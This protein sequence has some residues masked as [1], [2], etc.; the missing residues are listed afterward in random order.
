MSPPSFDSAASSPIGEARPSAALSAAIAES[1]DFFGGKR[2]LVTGAAGFVGGQ[3]ARALYRA[4]ARVTR[5]SQN[6]PWKRRQLHLASRGRFDLI[7]DLAAGADIG[8]EKLDGPLIALRMG[9]VFGPHALDFDAPIP[10]AFRNIFRDGESPELSVDAW[11]DFREYLFVEDAVCAY[12]L[13]ARCK[14]CH[15]RVFDVP[16][17]RYAATSDVLRDIVTCVGELQARAKIEAPASALANHLWN[18]SIR[19]VPSAANQDIIASQRLNDTHFRV[20][21][22]FEPQTSF[23]D[24]LKKT[25]QF[26]ACFFGKMAPETVTPPARKPNV[27]PRTERE[28]GFETVIADNGL[29]VEVLHPRFRG[30]DQTAPTRPPAFVLSVPG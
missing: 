17:V 18:R 27:G 12:L 24:G 15:G 3:L 8:G 20:A 13:A 30:A 23:R 7:F 10:G 4:G 14:S 6:L 11:E 9:E 22:G 29:P 25:A 28:S 19:I 26:Y 2:V 5:L 1:R 21:T 16:G